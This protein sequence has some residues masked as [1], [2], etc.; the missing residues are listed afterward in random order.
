MPTLTFNIPRIFLP[1]A[2]ALSTTNTDENS[3]SV[4]LAENLAAASSY[5]SKLVEFL[6]FRGDETNELEL[7]NRALLAAHPAEFLS[8]RDALGSGTVKLMKE[9]AAA[10]PDPLNWLLR[11]PEELRSAPWT[12]NR[13]AEWFA[14]A[15]ELSMSR[16][17][18]RSLERDM[19]PVVVSPLPKME[20]V[21]GSKKKVHE[22]ELFAQL[23]A[24][25]ADKTDCSTIVDAGS[26]LG[27]LGRQLSKYGLKVIGVERDPA[28]VER[29][30]R[31]Q[32]LV[33]KRRGI[34]DSEPQSTVSLGNLTTEGLLSLAANN[35]SIL[36]GLHACGELSSDLFR[37]FASPNS[38]YS[39]LVV[40]GCCYQHAHTFPLSSRVKTAI[41]STGIDPDTFLPKR[42]RETAAQSASAGYLSA[43]A[44]SARKTIR[45]KALA[46]AL[47]EQIHYKVHGS[48]LECKACAEAG[49]VFDVESG[50]PGKHPFDTQ[51]TFSQYVESAL[52]SDVVRLGKDLDLLFAGTLEKESTLF[53]TF[54]AMRHALGAV[55]ESLIVLDR[56]VFVV[57]SVGD[58]EELRVFSLFDPAVSPRNLVVWATRRLRCQQDPGGSG[59]REVD[60]G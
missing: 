11:S 55:A 54:T 35:S 36:V 32:L 21:S 48:G 10:E 40:A 42:A 12:D 27:R 25:I 59:A 16:E 18:I 43:Q 1:S 13:A 58:L 33:E 46:R 6:S 4:S 51:Q 37:T 26:G 5:A 23:V 8:R 29:A 28:V 47:L 56:A 30:E 17:G 45:E 41:A 38:P 50:L 53:A 20:S 39:A 15:L 60:E 34:A 44:K 3:A 14:K 7:D 57:E 22:V 24:R 9:A 49:L 2:E 19:D 52:G 31:K